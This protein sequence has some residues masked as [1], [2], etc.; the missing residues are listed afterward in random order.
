VVWV[1]LIAGFVLVEKSL[2]AG[3]FTSGFAGETLALSSAPSRRKRRMS[4]VTSTLLRAMSARFRMADMITMTMTTM[5]S[6]I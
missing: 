1:A 6:L 4:A 5:T 2:P 3:E